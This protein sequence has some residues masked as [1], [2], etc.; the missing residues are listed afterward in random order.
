[1]KVKSESEVARSSPTLSDPMDCS[2][3]VHISTNWIFRHPDLNSAGKYPCDSSLEFQLG[4]SP[5]QC[6][7]CVGET[8][9]CCVWPSLFIIPRS[10]TGIIISLGAK[11]QLWYYVNFLQCCLLCS[12]NLGMLLSPG[13]GW[14]DLPTR[15]LTNS[16]IPSLSIYPVFSSPNLQQVWLTP[17]AIVRTV[18][19][20]QKQGQRPAVLFCL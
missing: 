12:A 9:D 4:K 18:Q 1:M 15:D 14:P 2:P 16:K 20:G 10:Q 5:R 3:P 6:I 7:H 13:S 17:T 8:L 19:E 11:L